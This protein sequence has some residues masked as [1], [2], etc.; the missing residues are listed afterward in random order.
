MNTQKIADDLVAL[1]RAGKFDQAG[2]KYWADDVLSVEPAGEAAMSRGK[3]AARD[4]GEWWAGA[5]DVHG[6][7]I[8]GPYVNGDQFAVR[9]TIDQTVKETGHRMTL[10][11]VGLYTVKN[12]KIAEERFF[13]VG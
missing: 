3:Q 8:G 9:F 1:C 2:E 13:Y 10:D 5:H 6:V 11:E 12:G 7:D 4:K